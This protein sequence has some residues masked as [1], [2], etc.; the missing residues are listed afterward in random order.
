MNTLQLLRH[1]SDEYRG[2]V[3]A[4]NETLSWTVQMMSMM[5]AG[6]ASQHYNPRQIG[7]VA[8]MLSGSTAIFWGLAN[9]FGK[10][11][12][13]ALSGVDPREIE[14]HEEHGV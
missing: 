1:V 4:T 10:L 7:I 8:G 9:A 3:F 14:V 2:R 5:A 11:P 12:E 13:P 6:I